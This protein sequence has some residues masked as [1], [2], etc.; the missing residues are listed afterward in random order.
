LQCPSGLIAKRRGF[1]ARRIVTF[2]A[3]A[4]MFV[5]TTAIS[6]CPPEF[7][8][9]FPSLCE[10]GGGGDGGGEEGG[11]EASKSAAEPELARDQQSPDAVQPG[12]TQAEPER[13]GT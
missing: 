11:G 12:L 7:C 10:D 3:I 6:D 5:V 1:V 9:P 4:G 2:L 13:D 8:G